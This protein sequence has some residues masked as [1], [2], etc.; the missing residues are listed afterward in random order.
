MTDFNPYMSIKSLHQNYRSG[1]ISPVDVIEAHLA[2]EDRLEDKLNAYVSRYSDEARVLAKKAEAGFSSSDSQPPLA[3]VLIAL[4]D[5]V[6]MEGRITMGGS[7]ERR[8]R[9]SPSTAV[10]AQRLM[11][12]GAI[13][14]G[15]THTVEMASGGWGTNEHM[16]TPWNPW[17][18]VTH[19]T[20][21][22]SSSGSGV[23]V[24]AGYCPGAIGTDTGGSVRL[25]AAWCGLVGLKITEGVLPLEGILPLSSTLDSPGPLTRSIDDAIIMFEVLRGHGSAQINAHLKQTSGIF[26]DV[27]GS[28]KG[29]TLAVLPLAER[30][31][32]DR[33]I[34]ETYDKSVA[35]L[36][37]LGANIVEK[38]VPKAWDGISDE[39]AQVIIS[40]EGYRFNKEII[41]NNDAVMDQWVK[42][43][44]ILGRND[45]SDETYHAALKQRAAD[46]AQFKHEFGDIDAILTPSISTPAI[47]LEDVDELGSPAGFTR[48]AN[49]LAL[50]SL[51]IPNGFTAAGLPTSLMI[52]CHG[53]QETKALRIGKTYEAENSWV[54]QHPQGLD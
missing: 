47:P 49:Y 43:R 26:A 15:K 24:A 2:R 31:G 14:P 22:G 3:G 13:I 17:D 51:S 37:D 19:R 45:F 32:I 20:P 11:A 12:A 30:G 28:I 29:L 16:G 54:D 33:E 36:A 34:L 39:F 40:Y 35:C 18:L 10:I 41:D 5:L 21:G 23:A 44:L 50:C 38:A 8:T 7:P 4:K 42:R 1:E 46:L 52:T 9:I 53:M 27:R 48:A 6:D 25:P